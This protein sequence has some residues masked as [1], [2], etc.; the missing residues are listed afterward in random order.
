MTTIKRTIELDADTDAALV[1]AASASGLSP[2][3]FVQSA[4][5]QILTDVDDL[6][7][8]IRRWEAFEA[9]GKSVP[10]EDVDAWIDSLGTS[11]PLPKP[12]P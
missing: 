8:E 7:E 11:S 10:A 5:G 6:S 4:I 3:A 9:D 12:R 1:K 2:S